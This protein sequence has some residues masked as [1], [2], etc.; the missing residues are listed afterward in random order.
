[1]K[2]ILMIGISRNRNLKLLNRISCDKAFF[3]QEVQKLSIL[4]NLFFPCATRKMFKS[5]KPNNA[6][7]KHS[8]FKKSFVRFN[9]K[10]R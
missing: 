8:T 4:L 7:V 3:P 2:R 6:P 1:M 9:N 10:A 5:F